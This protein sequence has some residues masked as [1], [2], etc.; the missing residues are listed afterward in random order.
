MAQH[1]QVIE[2]GSGA[3]V[4]ADINAAFAA[5]FPANYGSIRLPI[6]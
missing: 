6:R 2:N 1:D 3:V 5:V 4:R